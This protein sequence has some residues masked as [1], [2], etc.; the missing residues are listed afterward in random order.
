MALKEKVNLQYLAQFGVNDMPCAGY[1]KEAVVPFNS[2]RVDF[3]EREKWNTGFITDVVIQNSSDGIL[4][5]WVL[6]YSSSD[7][8]EIKEIWNANSDVSN[9]TV[10]L[11]SKEYNSFVN[12]GDSVKL[13]FK[14][15]GQMETP[16]AFFI[17]GVRCESAPIAILPT[18][19]SAKGG[20]S[21]GA[22]FSV[23]ESWNTGFRVEVTLHNDSNEEIRDWSIEI[24]RAGYTIVD[25]WRTKLTQDNGTIIFANEVYNAVVPAGGT[26]TFGYVAQGNAAVA[27]PSEFELNGE[28]YSSNISKPTTACVAE[29]RLSD[30][31]NG[32][33][34]A[35]MNVENV[36][37][38]DILD[39]KATIN[40]ASSYK[41][42]NLWN[43]VD[44]KS[45]AILS[46]DAVDY[47]RVIRANGSLRFGFQGE[48][49]F[50][51]PSEIRINGTSCVVQ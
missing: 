18:G 46:V 24:P 15:F 43:G 51:A 3:V 6:T 40:N 48:G 45:G 28:S 32:G 22:S 10:S 50:T 13:G 37:T 31:W 21:L 5:D 44:N 47:N 33:F 29:L 12:P 27:I 7:S 35:R 11:Q 39:W 2:C 42:V 1:E 14:G 41:V 17:N 20:D 26:L 9:G 25:S 49:S 4:R 36:G 8:Y 16:Q 30:S 38:D 23:L 34:I 19:G